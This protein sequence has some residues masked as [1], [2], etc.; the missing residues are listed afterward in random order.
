M[1][2]LSVTASSPAAMSSPAAFASRSGLPLLLCLSH[3]RW[4][5]VFQRPQHLLCRAAR[6]YRVIFLEEPHQVPDR[7]A[8]P[9][10]ETR[11][12]AHGV[13]I[14]TPILP[15][16]MEPDTEIIAQAALLNGLIGEFGEP[17]VAWYYSSMFLPIAGHLEPSV[18]IYDCMDELSLFRGASPQLQLLERRL[19]KRADFVFAGGRSLYDAKRFLHSNAHLFPSSV[20]AVHFIPARFPSKLADPADQASLAHPRLGYFGVIDER[21]DLPLLAEIAD[22]RP[23]WQIVMVGP[24]VKIDPASLPQ[25]S[26]LHWLGGKL[27]EELP[28]YLAHWSFGLMPFAL[29][30]ATRFISPTKTPEFL[31]TGVPVIS[32][33]VADVVRDWGEPGL[34]EIA[35]TAEQVI[36]AAEKIA[37]RPR[38]EWLNRV[39]HRLDQTSWDRTWEGMNRL[40]RRILAPQRLLP[41]MAG[42]L[43]LTQAAD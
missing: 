34:V 3:L 16:G 21:L 1:P 37:A 22:R 32:T 2:S 27:Y 10:L 23:D 9:R 14:A 7:Q 20:D 40:I 39:D 26:N 30:E 43:D 8:A 18:T 12:T 19:L 13:L 35:A 41:R 38:E 5:F 33:P 11:V 4:D 17:A 24:V 29:N 31:A 28:S 42:S 6:D 36:E 15:Q 25:R